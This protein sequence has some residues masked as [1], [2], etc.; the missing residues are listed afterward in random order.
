MDIREA[1]KRSLDQ[2][3]IGLA[4]LN[5]DGQFLSY[6]MDYMGEVE[7][8]EFTVLQ[9]N[10]NPG[11]LSTFAMAA[12]EG[13]PRA[14]E[15]AYKKTAE[16][17]TREGVIDA[18][19]AHSLCYQIAAGICDYLGFPAPPTP[20]APGHNAV[21]MRSVLANNALNTTAGP[22]NMTASL[23]FGPNITSAGPQSNSRPN[24][25]G[26][27]GATTKSTVIYSGDHSN[28]GWETSPVATPSTPP[29]PKHHSIPAWLIGAG[30]GGALALLVTAVIMLARPKSVYAVPQLTS[31]TL[32][33]ALEVIDNSEH[34]EQGQITYQESETVAKDEIISQ[35][36]A[37]DGNA[38]NGTEIDLVVSSG[39]TNLE[40][41]VPSLEGLTPKE[42]T[43]RL[44]EAGLV[45]ER[46]IDVQSSSIAIGLV[47]KQSPAEGTKVSEGST[48]VYQLSLG[49]DK[50]KEIKAPNLIGLSSDDA[51]KALE[52]LGLVGQEGDPVASD[53]SK[54]TVA[55]QSP[56]ANTVVSKG[57]VIV[58]QLSKGPSTNTNNGV[59]YTSHAG[60]VLEHADQD[61]NGST[62]YYRL[63]TSENSTR[64]VARDIV[65]NSSRVIFDMP[66]GDGLFNLICDG[67]NI[68]FG[69]GNDYDDDEHFD[70]GTIARINLDGSGYQELASVDKFG[71]FMKFYLMGGRIYYYAG[72][73]VRSVEIDGTGDRT[74]VQIQG[75]AEFFCTNG[76][77]YLAEGDM[78]SFVRIEPDGSRTRIYSGAPWDNFTVGTTSLILT[79]RTANG[80]S[81]RWVD[82]ASGQETGTATFGD[83]AMDDKG[84]TAYGDDAIMMLQYD[85]GD[86]QASLYRIT[87][88]GSVQD[89]WDRSGLELVIRP[90]ALGD[91][92]YFSA[93]VDATS[94]CTPCSVSIG[95]GDFR[96][97]ESELSHPGL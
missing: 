52:E 83:A 82:I 54:G 68:Y 89:L 70:S 9:F 36:P 38:P 48:V 14:L 41:K 32:A 37:A 69:I 85:D 64:I 43:K 92:V 27:M 46:S 94:T 97:D 13:N 3:G 77:L 17:L 73:A 51:L 34:F 20:L 40:V 23:G 61:L 76:N 58:Y 53:F 60:N 6:V 57:D 67:Q 5:N 71:K 59:D 25:L 93:Y 11:I 95:G 87:R 31:L 45:G 22:S 88:S 66:H 96:I 2:D 84:I 26:G 42:A 79:S 44:E 33:E 47:A 62:L 72:G 91:R 35:T 18:T 4:L 1:V 74:D 29:D 7:S 21:Q 56:S 12:R 50:P 30:V 55:Q 10:L 28:L 63:F 80:Y 86:Q 49:E 75:D 90:H 15:F 24:A 81:L 78:C 65:T 39:G 19:V 16:Q 8:P